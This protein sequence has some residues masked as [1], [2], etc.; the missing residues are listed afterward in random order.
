MYLKKK[1]YNL[2]L[3]FLFWNKKVQ[4]FWQTPNLFNCCSNSEKKFKVLGSD[5]ILKNPHG[6]NVYVKC[7]RMVQAE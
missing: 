7:V 5:I 1:V 6:I 4:N 3:F 2:C